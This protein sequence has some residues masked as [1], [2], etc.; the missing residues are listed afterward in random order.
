MQVAVLG[1]GIMGTGMARSLLRAGHDVRVWNRT[2]VKAESLEQHGATVADSAPD[3]VRD[4]EAVVTMLFDADAVVEVMAE[5]DLPDDC[6]WLQ[7]STVGIEGTH[8]VA[9]LADDRG[10]AVLDAPVLGTKAPAFDGKLVVLVSGE[11]Q[12]AERMQPVFDAIGGRTVYAGDALGAATALK[13][14]C[15]AWIGTLTAALGQSL[16]LAEGLGVDPR[17]FLEAIEGG[18]VDMPYV[19]VKSTAMLERSYDTSFAVDGVVKDL[20]LIRAAAAQGGVSDNL[21]TA[22]RGLFARTSESGRGE[23]DMAAV[24]TAFR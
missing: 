7:S 1:T 19:H 3:A 6:V 11:K 4:A 22:A 10:L 14:V 16:A 17:Q 9:R 13:L 2:K 8:R 20:D 5:V 23:Q 12:A 24:H 21:L 18:P 15:N